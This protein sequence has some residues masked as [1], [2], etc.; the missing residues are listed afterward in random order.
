MSECL[1]HT[2]RIHTRKVRVATITSHGC[3]EQNSPWDRNTLRTVVVSIASRCVEV[4]VWGPT[5][6]EVKL[7]YKSANVG[8]VGVSKL[9]KTISQHN[10]KQSYGSSNHSLQFYTNTVLLVVQSRYSFYY[11]S[12]LYDGKN[13]HYLSSIE[14]MVSLNIR[15]CI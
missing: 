9:L 4:G 11:S 10:G 6:K 15:T 2:V 14:L 7:I 8:Q 3:V 5:L 12:I 1:P 13:Q